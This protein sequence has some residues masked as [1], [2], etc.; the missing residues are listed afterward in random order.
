MADTCLTFDAYALYLSNIL[1]IDR[2]HRAKAGAG[3]TIYTFTWIGLWMCFQE[4]S[5]LSL[6]ILRYIIGRCGITGHLQVGKRTS[7]PKSFCHPPRNVLH[8]TKVLLIWAPSCQRFRKR[9]WHK[10]SGIRQP[11]GWQSVQPRSYHNCDFQRG[12]LPLPPRHC[13]PNWS[14]KSASAY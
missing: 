14:G 4:L 6:L 11:A 8:K 12:Q 10:Q 7:I 2:P 3:P 9:M 5:R 1:R 13:Q